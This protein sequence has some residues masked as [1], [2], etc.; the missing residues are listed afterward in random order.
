MGIQIMITAGRLIGRL[1]NELIIRFQP[2]RTKT[3]PIEI[4]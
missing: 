4:V 2:N 3:R 1:P